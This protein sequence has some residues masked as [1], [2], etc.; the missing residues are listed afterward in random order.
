MNQSHIFQRFKHHDKLPK[1]L[2]SLMLV[3]I[4]YAVVIKTRIEN[5]NTQL[6]VKIKTKFVQYG[7][8]TWSTVAVN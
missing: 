7:S 1:R 5:K 6:V 2:H 3:N 8:L 4:T